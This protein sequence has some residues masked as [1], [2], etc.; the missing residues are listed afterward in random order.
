MIRCI[1]NWECSKGFLNHFATKLKFI[2]ILTIAIFRSKSYKGY[3]CASICIGE[4]YCNDDITDYV[5][6]LYFGAPESAW[7]IHTF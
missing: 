4:V 3:D 2:K 6:G 5:N 1:V 7:Q